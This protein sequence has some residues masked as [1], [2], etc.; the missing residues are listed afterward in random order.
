[1]ITVL[2]KHSD[3]GQS[4][5]EQRHPLSFI[6]TCPIF[7]SFCPYSSSLPFAYLLVSTLEAESKLQEASALLPVCASDSAYE[8]AQ[9]PVGVSASSDQPG[10]SEILPEQSSIGSPSLHSP[11]A[12]PQPVFTEEGA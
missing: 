6:Y 9:P 5:E 4:S 8:P 2:A 11:S 3:G 10:Q 7:F 12:D 1:M